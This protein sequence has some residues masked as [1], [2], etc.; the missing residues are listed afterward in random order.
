MKKISFAILLSMA[1]LSLQASFFGTV[2]Q[3]ATLPIRAT[4]RTTRYVAPRLIRWSIRSPEDALL[5]GALAACAIVAARE[6]WSR[7]RVAVRPVNRPHVTLKD[8]IMLG[9]V[10]EYNP[11]KYAD[12]PSTIRTKLEHLYARSGLVA[13]DFSDLV[14]ALKELNPSWNS[15][16]F[17][18]DFDDR[19]V[20]ECRVCLDSI[21]SQGSST[22]NQCKKKT[23]S[24]CLE[25]WK[26]ALFAGAPYS[27]PLCRAQDSFINLAHR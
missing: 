6:H 11:K 8:L 17:R 14:D 27:C 18:K 13:K 1:I 24:K 19:L 22:C 21:V 4:Y 25:K 15:S 3:V 23:H 9:L 10:E 5:V 2:F 26:N 20:E 12:L 7:N 16:F